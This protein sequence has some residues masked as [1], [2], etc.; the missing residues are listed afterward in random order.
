[1]KVLVLS[2]IHSNWPALSAVDESFDACLF[3]GDLVDYATGADLGLPALALAVS[4]ETYDIGGSMQTLLTLSYPISLGAEGAS[5]HIDASTDLS[6][7]IDAAPYTEFVSQTNL[8]DGRAMVTVHF[9]SPIGDGPQH[10]LRLRVEQ[11]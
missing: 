8:G 1:M 4:S 6:T 7:W 5:I 10:F 11:L 2:D 3:L 9:T